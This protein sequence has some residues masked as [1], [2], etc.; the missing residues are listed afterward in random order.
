MA[1]PDGRGFLPQAFSKPQS[2][3]FGNSRR[4]SPIQAFSKNVRFG[5]MAVIPNCT[6]N[7]RTL[8]DGNMAGP[9]WVTERVKRNLQHWTKAQLSPAWCE[10]ILSRPI[11]LQTRTHETDACYRLDSGWICLFPGSRCSRRTAAP[12]GDLLWWSGDT[13]VC[14]ANIPGKFRRRRNDVGAGL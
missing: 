6:R 7:R 12:I 3:R 5:S 8:R 11:R 1:A 9:A 4:V 14:V 13:P 10:E 2:S